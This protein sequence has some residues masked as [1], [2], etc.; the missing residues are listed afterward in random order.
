MS[1][2]DHRPSAHPHSILTRSSLHPHPNIN[3]SSPHPH[4]ILISL[5]PPR[6][7]RSPL[8]SNM[9]I[10]AAFHT[11][12]L[13]QDVPVLRLF[14]FP[15]G[16]GRINLLSFPACPWRI[17][18]VSSPPHLYHIILGWGLPDPDGTKL[19]VPD[20]ELSDSVMRGPT[21]SRQSHGWSDPSGSRWLGRREKFPSVHVLPGL[22]CLWSPVV[23][24]T[25]GCEKLTSPL[26]WE[27]CAT[28]YHHWNSPGLLLFLLF[29]VAR[30]MMRT[31]P[32]FCLLVIEEIHLVVAVESPHW[33]HDDEVRVPSNG[34]SVIRSLF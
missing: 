12:P 3:A 2:G 9:G 21:S 19:Q 17:S 27:S 24:V 10:S 16:S 22:S 26:Q 11:S 28:K 23:V 30:L 34:A 1:Q 20:S 13:P 14:S 32:K 31:I 4:P 29:D 18:H 33:K 5:S 15:L 8:V 6:V 25:S 7:E